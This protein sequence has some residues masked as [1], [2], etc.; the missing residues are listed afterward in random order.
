M[1]RGSAITKR[2]NGQNRTDVARLLDLMANQQP[3]PAV[4]PFTSGWAPNDANPPPPNAWAPAPNVPIAAEIASPNEAPPPRTDQLHQSQGFATSTHYFGKPEDDLRSSTNGF[5]AFDAAKCG[6]FEG[7]GTPKGSAPIPPSNEAPL[8]ST[9]QLHQAEAFPKSTYCRGFTTFQFPAPPAQF[10]RQGGA[11]VGVAWSPSPNL[12]AA[13]QMPPSDEV[14]FSRTEQLN[15][16]A[17]FATDTQYFAKSEGAAHSSIQHI[18]AFDAA[19]WSSV[20]ASSQQISHVEVA[21]TSPVPQAYNDYVIKPSFPDM[22]RSENDRPQGFAPATN[23]SRTDQNSSHHSSSKHSDTATTKKEGFSL[24]KRGLPKQLS[25]GVLNPRRSSTPSDN[26]FSSNSAKEQQL[27]GSSLEG[28]TAAAQ[29]TKNNFAVDA[30]LQGRTTPGSLASSEIYH[31]TS[32]ASNDAADTSERSGPPAPAADQRTDEL[33]RTTPFAWPSECL[34]FRS[35]PSA[36]TQ[37]MPHLPAASP[38]TNWPGCLEKTGFGSAREGA[39]DKQQTE[40]VEHRATLNPH[41]S[42]KP[43]AVP[44]AAVCNDAWQ[45]A[46]TRDKDDEEYAPTVSVAIE[47]LEMQARSLNSFE[48]CGHVGIAIANFLKTYADNPRPTVVQQ[49]AYPFLKD[50]RPVAVRAPTGSGKTV[51]F[52]L[53]ILENLIKEGG[54]KNQNPRCIVLVDTR[55]LCEQHWKTSLKIIEQLERFN[56]EVRVDCHM[57]GDPFGPPKH[58]YDGRLSCD[59]AFISPGRLMDYLGGGNNSKRAFNKLDLSELQ[60]IVMDEADELFFPGKFQQEMVTLGKELERCRELKGDGYRPCFTLFSATL[61]KTDPDLR[62]SCLRLGE[63]FDPLKMG[64]VEVLQQQTNIVQTVFLITQSYQKLQLLVKLL[65]R[66]LEMMGMTR[67]HS[68]RATSFDFS[69]VIFCNQRKETYMLASYLTSHYGFNVVAHNSSFPNE[70]RRRNLQNLEA[71]R[72]PFIVATNA[73]SRGIDSTRIKH[74]ILYGV[75]NTNWNSYTHRVGRTGRRGTEGRASIF[76][77]QSEEDD[78]RRGAL[79]LRTLYLHGQKTPRFLF[80]SYRAQAFPDEQLREPT[81]SMGEPPA[82]VDFEA[83]GLDVEEEVYEEDSDTSDSCLSL[84]RLEP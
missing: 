53:P 47:P 19:Q 62:R 3:A 13:D 43:A 81:L 65:D 45:A 32:R 49:F 20:Q 56:L 5:P 72:L 55:E 67:E 33:N 64:S 25:K 4:A 27:P 12:P 82:E 75:P 54:K 18:A 30:P 11:P 78:R 57:G 74:V 21:P 70:V 77:D 22:R 58:M 7:F 79:L 24:F 63:D 71:G 46:S 17:A 50:R 73:L 51:A 38:A 76:F 61:Y 23:T 31:A 80:E 44:P 28:A 42:N 39:F 2:K 9:E 8:P 59:I 83:C 34:T 29:A 16:S 48:E 68:R 36:D 15:Q 10:P 60:Y 40:I 41:P 66:D 1:G 6:V 14:S 52:L 84:A 69:T 37:S 35:I 26:S